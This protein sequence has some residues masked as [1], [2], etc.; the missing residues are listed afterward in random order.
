MTSEIDLASKGIDFAT[1]NAESI[2][3]IA[4]Q[5]INGSVKSLRIRTRNAYVNYIKNSLPYI[6]FTKSFF[7]RDEPTPLY[8]F[9]VPMSVSMRSRSFRQADFI[10]L[11]SI[12]RTIII[13]CSAG[14]GKSIFAKHLFV[15]AIEYSDNIP[16]FIELRSLNDSKS[17]ISES[18]YSNLSDLGFTLGREYVD[19]GLKLGHFVLILDGFDEIEQDRRGA[20]SREIERLSRRF[21]RCTIIISSRPD[22]IFNGWSNFVRI[23]LNPLNLQEA[24]L[25]IRKLPY[26]E[27]I[28]KK[29]SADLKNGLFQSH[30]SFLSNPLLLSIMLMTYGRTAEIPNKISLFYSEAFSALF[31]RHDASKGAFLRDRKCKLDIRE[32]ER[33][34][35]AFCLQT[36]DRRAFRFTKLEALEYLDKAF[37]SF[38]L[39][40]ESDLFFYDLQ[41][42]V[43]LIIEDGL[44]YT[45]SHRSFQEYFVALYISNANPDFQPDLIRRFSR[46]WTSDNVT[47]LLY[48]INQTLVEREYL[49]P[50]LKELF[51]DIGVRRKIGITHF[52][53]FF[54]KIIIE[55]ESEEDIGMLFLTSEDPFIE[56]VYRFMFLIVMKEEREYYLEHNTNSNDKEFLDKYFGPKRDK[57]IVVSELKMSDEFFKDVAIVGGVYSLGWLTQ[58]HDYF[59]KMEKKH[60]NSS[61]SLNSLLTRQKH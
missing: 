57:I 46:D 21:P 55:I 38:S 27:E 34:L 32:F 54:K 4:K 40:K 48:E 20:I 10:S 6:L 37:E 7:I 22:D 31:H 18:I 26:D 56:S 45:F 23:R 61:K 35:S 8:D 3:D 60:R 15:S 17:N 36:Y 59:L 2:F 16:I 25:L 41:Q 28:K 53:R 51:N 50:V 14:G 12:S 5:T 13:E 11:Q 33:I 43:S 44:E 9:Y 19:L 29:F 30:E 49:I 1:R 24:C 47:P 42:S 39:D 58:V 52:T